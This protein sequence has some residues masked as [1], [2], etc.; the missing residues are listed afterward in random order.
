M[1]PFFFL[2]SS[3]T[4]R[5]LWEW[6]HLS[7]LWVGAAAFWN[8]HSW[9]GKHV[10]TEVLKTWIINRVGRL[11]K[12]SKA[13][14]EV[15]GRWGRTFLHT[16]TICMWKLF[17]CDWQVNPWKL[18]TYNG[19]VHIASKHSLWCVRKMSCTPLWSGNVW[20]NAC[21]RTH[22]EGSCV[23]N[24][25]AKFHVGNCFSFYHAWKEKHNFSDLLLSESVRQPC[26]VI[27]PSFNFSRNREKQVTCLLA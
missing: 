5:G 3:A 19:K 23:F 18:G 9:S 27:F 6:Q 12:S 13:G 8:C 1:K 25:I 10:F 15:G 26:Y 14:V 20:V 21:T 7:S 17:F 24:Y 11:E 22:A 2:T 4:G 16:K